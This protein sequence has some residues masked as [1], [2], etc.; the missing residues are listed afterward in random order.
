RE[1]EHFGLVAL[2]RPQ[3]PQPLDRPAECEL[4][5]AEPLDEVPAP[6]GPEGL[7]R[8]QVLVDSAVAAGDTLA[9]DPVACDD[10]LALEH[11]LRER[12]RVALA[13]EEPRGE[14]PAPLRRRRT[15]CARAGESSSVTLL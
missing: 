3:L 8:A 11:E 4:S 2:P 5:A 13:G 7:E 6:A 10:A 9:A 1:H 12:A 15:G 14:R